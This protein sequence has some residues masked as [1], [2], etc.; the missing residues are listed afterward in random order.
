[1]V[2]FNEIGE[3]FIMFL[4]MTILFY[5]SF[6]LIHAIGSLTKGRAIALFSKA[7]LFF[8]GLW[9]VTILTIYA[10]SFLFPEQN[11]P[12][13]Y[14]NLADLGES[15]ENLLSVFIPTNLVRAFATDA[16]PAVVLFSL[17]FGM[18]LIQLPSKTSFLDNVKTVVSVLTNI[19]R[20]VAN[21]SPIG[22][23]ALIASSMGTMPLFTYGSKY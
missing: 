7:L 1:M 4:K 10:V 3:A 5:V 9:T 22:C 17:L 11:V 6:S 2:I 20:W 21:L 23:F 13:Y 18:A 14:S 8:L 12:I 19:T 16:I 15:Q